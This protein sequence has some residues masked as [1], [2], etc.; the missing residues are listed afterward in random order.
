M[1]LARMHHHR[2]SRSDEP[3]TLPPITSFD[4][5]AP[6]QP[7]S[8]SN[9]RPSV[10]DLSSSRGP[11][12]LQP[13]YAPP[14]A[15]G[16]ARADSDSLINRSQY[17]AAPARSASVAESS[18]QPVSPTFSRHSYE[19]EQQRNLRGSEPYPT[20]QAFYPVPAA[21][22]QFPPPSLVRPLTGSST[23]R[24]SFDYPFRYRQP[25]PR[26]AHQPLERDT[27]QKLIHVRQR[28]V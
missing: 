20:E 27:E 7:R 1:Q 8:L 9:R 28:C 2:S 12:T 5:D 6:A 15:S 16:H 19:G 24:E 25:N 10:L 13:S 18:R 26:S 4:R 11:L 22:Y 21:V 14:P 3:L 17:V 23:Q